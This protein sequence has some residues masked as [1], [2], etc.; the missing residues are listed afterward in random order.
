[1]ND[2]GS[3]RFI[4]VRYYCTMGYSSHPA[5]TVQSTR[6]AQPFLGRLMLQSDVCS[7]ADTKGRMSEMMNPL[8]AP[9]FPEG[10]D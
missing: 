7:F 3:K 2:C 10:E 5:S 9:C 4:G 1:V 8:Q 6:I